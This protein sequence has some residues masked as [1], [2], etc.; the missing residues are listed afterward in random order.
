MIGE[1]TESSCM[2]NNDLSTINFCNQFFKKK[3]N[4]LTIKT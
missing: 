1:S 3:N 4:I 2:Y